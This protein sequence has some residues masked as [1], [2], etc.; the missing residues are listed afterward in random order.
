[1]REASGNNVDVDDEK[2]DVYCQDPNIF[3]RQS[4]FHCDD[5]LRSPAAESFLSLSQFE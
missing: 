5:V 4:R 3:T 1:M 2:L